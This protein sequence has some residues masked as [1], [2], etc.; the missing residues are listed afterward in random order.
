MQDVYL[1][2]D[3]ISRQYLVRGNNGYLLIDTGL[4]NNYTNLLKRLEKIGVDESTLEFVIIT[5]ADGDHFGCLA[6]L[7]DKYPAMVA[8]SSELEAASIKRG[9]SSRP[10]KANGVKKFLYALISP[11]FACKPAEIHRILQPGE[12]FPYLGGLEILDTKGHTPEHISLWSKS[13]KTLFSGDSIVINGQSLSPSAGSKDR[14]SV[15]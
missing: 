4:K 1:L 12:V 6:Q 9:E 2:H 7:M 13:T 8:A 14:K 10:L 3:S 11:L 5:H 15:V